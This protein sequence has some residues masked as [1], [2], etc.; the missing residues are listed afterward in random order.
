MSDCD[1]MPKI[2]LNRKK[3]G[4]HFPATST[5]HFIHRTAGCP[6]S[7]YL[8]L[9]LSGLKSLKPGFSEHSPTWTEGYF[10]MIFSHRSERRRH[11]EGRITCSEVLSGRLYNQ[12]PQHSCTAWQGLYYLCK[13]FALFPPQR[14]YNCLNRTQEENANVL[15]SWQST[16]DAFLM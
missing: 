7:F 8:E 6:E 5:P 4:L 16:Y 1:R 14:H 9:L 13:P 10:K 2:S 3:K 11:R 12:E 15:S